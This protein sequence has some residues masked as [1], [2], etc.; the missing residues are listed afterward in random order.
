[1]FHLT[2]NIES[3]KAIT[4]ENSEANAANLKVAILPAPQADGFASSKVQMM[5][6]VSKS[7][8]QFTGIA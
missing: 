8:E 3:E 2:G 6:T 5:T 4:A 7:K 1:M